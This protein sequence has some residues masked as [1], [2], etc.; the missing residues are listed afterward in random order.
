MKNTVALAR[1]DW[2]ARAGARGSAASLLWGVLAG[3]LVTAVLLFASGNVSPVLVTT[4]Q[5][6]LRF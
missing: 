6:F 1:E 4:L 5:L 2:D 3:E